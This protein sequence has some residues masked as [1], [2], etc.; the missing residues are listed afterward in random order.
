[1]S[2]NVSL[3]YL[4]RM[5]NMQTTVKWQSFSL[6]IFEASPCRDNLQ[7][8]VWKFGPN[9]AFIMYLEVPLIEFVRDCGKTGIKN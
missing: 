2:P 5:E 7:D 3:P 4:V 6:I 8:L 1:M 9:S